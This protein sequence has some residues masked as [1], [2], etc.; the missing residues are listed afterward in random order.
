M[1]ECAKSPC[2]NGGSCTNTAGSFTCKCQQGFQGKLCDQGSILFISQLRDE[3]EF[4]HIHK[5]NILWNFLI[6]VGTLLSFRGIFSLSTRLI[7]AVC[8]IFVTFEPSCVT[9]SYLI[10]ETQ[11]SGRAGELQERSCVRT[12]H[13][14]L[15]GEL[16]ISSRSISSLFHLLVNN[17]HKILVPFRQAA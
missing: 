17:F 4:G 15:L 14:C 3:I 11:I 9:C 16:R 2:K 7:E 1:D 13:P 8:G 10:P 5:A 12:P 6:F